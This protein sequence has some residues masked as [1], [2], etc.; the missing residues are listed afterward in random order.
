ML[1]LWVS[2]QHNNYSLITTVFVRK[3]KQVPSFVLLLLFIWY[4]NMFLKCSLSKVL[5]KSKFSHGPFKSC[6]GESKCCYEWPVQK[7]KKQ[8][9]PSASP[10]RASYHTW[11]QMVLKVSP[12]LLDWPRNK[13]TLRQHDHTRLLELLFSWQIT[14]RMGTEPI[15]LQTTHLK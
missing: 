7:T 15:M 3:L 11:W 1:M 13:V 9:I 10:P 14:V 8:K 2:W 6:M 4:D 5:K 12:S